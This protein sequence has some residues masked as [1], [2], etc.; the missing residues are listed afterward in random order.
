M[1]EKDLIGIT[2]PREKDREKRGS[3]TFILWKTGGCCVRLSKDLISSRVT[4]PFD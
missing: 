3:R 2:D 1:K 4:N